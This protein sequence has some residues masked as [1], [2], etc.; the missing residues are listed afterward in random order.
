MA[1]RPGLSAQLVVVA[2]ALVVSLAAPA[3]ARSTAPTVTYRVSGGDAITVTGRT[4]TASPVVR[5]KRASG[6]GWVVVKRLRAHRHHFAATVG[7]A[8]GTTATFRVTSDRRSRTFRVAMPAAKKAAPAPTTTYDACG[9]QPRKADGTAWSCSFHDEFAGT[10]LDRTKWVPQTI[11]ASGSPGAYACYADDPSVVNVANGSLNLTVRRVATP[12]SC[13]ADGQ[14]VS[15]SY[16]A[17]MVTTYHLFSQQY[18]RFEARIRN[19]ATA[20]PG[21]HEA[22]WL[23]PDDRVAST[24]VWPAAGEIDVSETYSAHPD[25]SIPFLHYAADVAGPQPGVNTA[26]NC[27][28]Y[29][30]QWNTYA[31]EWTPTRI[32]ILVNGRSCLVNTSADP[33]F[34][35]P[36]IVA[37]TQGLGTAGNEYD[38]RAPIPATMNVDY[39]RVWR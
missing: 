34:L 5:I 27:T 3:S 19:T 21:L 31:L 32:E 30:G 26:W 4:A 1:L 36:Y 38:G 9:A 11:F 25:L 15:T 14:S 23:W 35:K 17:G 2:L 22:F 37:F 12:V 16:L 18:G 8:A 33:A 7:L 13:Q 10:S 24:A 28:A 6:W 20:A 39:L 29:R